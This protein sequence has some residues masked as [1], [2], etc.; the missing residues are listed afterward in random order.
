METF[1]VISRI[2]SDYA[3]RFCEFLS[4]KMPIVLHAKNAMQDVNGMGVIFPVNAVIDQ[5]GHI[6]ISSRK[7]QLGYIQ[8]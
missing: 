5:A 4:S 8:G 2:V 6:E 3:V 1:A 7:Y